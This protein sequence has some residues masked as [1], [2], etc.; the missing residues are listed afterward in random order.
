MKILFGKNLFTSVSS[1][2]RPWA[3][4]RCARP[5]LV[6]IINLRE[7]RAPPL[8]FAGE[9]PSYANHPQSLSFSLSL[10]RSCCYYEETASPYSRN[11]SF[12]SAA[13]TM[14]SGLARD[15]K[16]LLA[17][18]PNGT[19]HAKLPKWTKAIRRRLGTSLR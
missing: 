2:R 3:F 9:N 6:I 11:L 7:L 17:K 16:W 1:T 15:K 5:R 18:K 12:S 4:R 14:H 10:W 8:S 13:E 19:R